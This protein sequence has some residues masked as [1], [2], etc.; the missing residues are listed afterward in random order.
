MLGVSAPSTG[1][2]GFLNLSWLAKKKIKMC[3]SGDNLK[4]TGWTN[5]GFTLIEL[6]VVIA[7]IGVLATVVIFVIDPVE[8][9]ARARDTG[10]IS[11]VTQ[12]GHT[13]QAYYTSRNG[14]Y[15]SESTWGQDLL[16]TAD[17]STFP[18]GIAYR[19]YSVSNCTTVPQPAI[20]P[21]YCYDLDTAGTNGAIIFS[22]AESEAKNSLC[23]SPEVAYYVFSTVDGRAGTI[24]ASTEPTPWASGTQNYLD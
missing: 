2:G 8:R 10:R 4:K 13:I 3:G 12:L 21:T 18:A 22:R 19:A 15:P 11:S 20:D 16:S 1:I 24:C 5:H 23:T 9:Q 14:Q 6:L 7:I 17:I